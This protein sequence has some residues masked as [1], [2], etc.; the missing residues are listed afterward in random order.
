MKS[1][2]FIGLGFMGFPM[3]E[4]ILRKGFSLTIYNR[5]KEK[6]EPLLA[7]G[8]LWAGSPAELAEKTDIV[9][10]MV[11]N[12]EA[13]R[14]IVLGPKG[15]LESRHKGKI[16]LSMSTVSPLLVRELENKYRE[17]GGALLSAP[18]SGRPERAKEG[19]LWIFLSGEDKAKL[20]A[21]SV[22]KAMSCKIFDFGQEAEKASIFKLCGNFMIL[23]FIETLSEAL[24]VLEKSGMS[25]TQAI[26]VW[27]ESFYDAPIFHSYG[28]IL[29][30]GIFK[31]GGFSLDLASKDM[32]LL[33]AF[34]DSQQVSLPILLSV[35]EKQ[36][37]AIAMG[38]GG[39]DCT[40]IDLVTRKQI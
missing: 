32:G 14:Q 2:G 20:A 25:R 30:K 1:V 37:A 24:S 13:L 27:G 8:A 18:V 12:D 7:K 16:H 35:E 40:V 6:A 19:T 28:N 22:L 5:T 4:N 23:S 21:S 17:N 9:I 15:L 39:V 26:E 11:S 31:E 29:A 10:T 34:A 3:A 36:K 33:K 38:H